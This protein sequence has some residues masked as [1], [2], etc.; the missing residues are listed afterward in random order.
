MKIFIETAKPI[1]TAQLMLLL[2]N[3]E[4]VSFRLEDDN[5]TTAPILEEGDKELNPR[6]LFGIWKERP[7]TLEEIRARTW[8]RN[9]NL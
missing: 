1:E 2:K 8:K 3:L 9:W 6:A 5:F 4:I 7:R